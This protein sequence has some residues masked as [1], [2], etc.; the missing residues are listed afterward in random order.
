MRAIGIHKALLLCGL[1][2]LALPCAQARPPDDERPGRPDRSY[3]DPRQTRNPDWRSGLRP[4][5]DERSYKNRDD[6]RPDDRRREDWQRD[7]RRYEQPR[8][9]DRR[10]QLAP[11]GMSLSDAVSEAERRTGGRVLSAEPREDDG[12]LYYRVKVLTPNGR[13]QLLHIDAR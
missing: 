5:R 8:Y 2:L 12:Q 11:R 3:E 13:V 6:D 1:L 4:V 10:Y 7:D 9:D